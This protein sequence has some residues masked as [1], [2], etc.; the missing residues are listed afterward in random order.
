M[1]KEGSMK[2]FALL[3]SVLV[4]TAAAAPA[5]A[6]TVHPTPSSAANYAK[7]HHSMSLTNPGAAHNT[8]GTMSGAGCQ[9]GAV[10]NA[11]QL[12][13]NPINGRAQAAPIISIPITKGGGSVASATTKAQQAHAC[14]HTR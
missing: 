2:R 1:G 11:A 3:L 5:V 12:A 13:V 4:A 10:A 14:A 9:S 7:V 8:T 6:Q